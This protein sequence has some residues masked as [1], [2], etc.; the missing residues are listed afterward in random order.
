MLEVLWMPTL[1]SIVCFCVSLYLLACKKNTTKN[2]DDNVS[3]HL[4]FFRLR[5]FLRIQVKHQLQQRKKSNL[6]IGSST[7]TDVYIL[8]ITLWFIQS[9][10]SVYLSV[11]PIEI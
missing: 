8:Y 2:L 5:P 11:S 4:N 3:T 10:L 1:S 9:N 7:S 6:N